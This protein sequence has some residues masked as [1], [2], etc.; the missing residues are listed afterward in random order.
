MLVTKQNSY[1]DS[2]QHP[3]TLQRNKNNSSYFSQIGTN[4]LRS[5][6]PWHGPSP[7]PI[8]QSITIML[9]DPQEEI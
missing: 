1:V 9:W 8:S 3:V 7:L 4:W 5:L 6:G 2:T